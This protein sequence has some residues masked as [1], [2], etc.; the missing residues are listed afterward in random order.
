MELT[1]ASPKT[2]VTLMWED[3]ATPT[4]FLLTVTTSGS[5]PPHFQIAP[6]APGACAQL[7]TATP[8]S[9]CTRVACPATGTVTAGV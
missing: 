5:P 6:S 3:A 1:V 2:E 7:P 8:Q 4:R 9:F